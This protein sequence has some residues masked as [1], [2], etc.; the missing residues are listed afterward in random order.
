MV[1]MALS[2]I[3]KKFDDEGDDEVP[4]VAAQEEGVPDEY[5]EVM[6]IGESLVTQ[7]K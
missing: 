2:I 1:A 7:S 6:N 4:V 5:D 3:F